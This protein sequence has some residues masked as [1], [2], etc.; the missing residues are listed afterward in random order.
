LADSQDADARIPLDSDFGIDTDEIEKRLGNWESIR[1]EAG[2]IDAFVGL[3]E[4]SVN[5]FLY[6]GKVLVIKGG[7]HQ[8]VGD[9]RAWFKGIGMHSTYDDNFIVDGIPND[10]FYKQE[11]QAILIVETGGTFRMT[12]EGNDEFLPLFTAKAARLCETDTCGDYF[13]GWN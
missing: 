8:M 7:F 13:K 11:Q 5:P 2:P 6:A 4:I 12:R 1:K 10:L 9:G 3:R